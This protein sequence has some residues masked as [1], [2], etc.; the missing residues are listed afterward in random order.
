MFFFYLKSFLKNIRVCP[1]CLIY[2]T[3]F[4]KPQLTQHCKKLSRNT[5]KTPF[6][7]EIFQDTCFLLVSEKNL[8]CT[9]SRQLK[10]CIL[11]LLGKQMSA[12]SFISP[13][14]L[15][16]FIGFVKIQLYFIILI[17]F[18]IALKR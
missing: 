4:Y 3:T 13:R 12:Y 15:L 8:H 7:L 18:S 11:E 10:N 1:D 16:A 2:N 17:L 5:A 14:K 9:T 6:T